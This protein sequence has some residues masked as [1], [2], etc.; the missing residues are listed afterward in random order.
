[1]RLR[2]T[3]FYQKCRNS[4]FNAKLD[5][6]PYK[7][8]FPAFLYNFFQLK[9]FCVF[10]ETIFNNFLL[11]NCF[12]NMGN[13]K[14]G[15]MD[16][17]ISLVSLCRKRYWNT[18]SIEEFHWGKVSIYNVRTSIPFST[19]RNE[20]IMKMLTLVFKMQKLPSPVFRL[21][22]PGWKSHKKFACTDL[23]EA[24]RRCTHAAP[25]SFKNIKSNQV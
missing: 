13:L 17:D 12:K 23:L 25:R 2:E 16:W 10:L 5:F 3:R 7:T 22:V 9:L 15:N 8:R 19:G 4:N 6:V 1:M 21:Q 14:I 11:I 18:Y 24:V 20:P